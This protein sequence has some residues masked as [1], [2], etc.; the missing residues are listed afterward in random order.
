M[1]KFLLLFSTV[2]FFYSCNPPGAY[3]VS[4]KVDAYVPVYTSLASI[5][6]ISVGPQQLTKNAGK[7]YAYGNF[8]FQNDVNAGV[9]IIDNTDKSSPKKIAFLN[10]PLNTEIAVKGNYLYA[11]NYVDLVVFDITNPSNPTMVKRV[12][13]VFPAEN[14]DYPPNTNVYF[15]CVDKS[16]GVVI[17]W[18]IKNI[19][20]PNCRR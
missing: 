1:I 19:D 18:E 10:L 4:G 11:N 5:D 17:R 20:A 16:K 14:Q 3:D 6:Q 2:I 13:N 15:E 9:H 12:K 7:I 8:I